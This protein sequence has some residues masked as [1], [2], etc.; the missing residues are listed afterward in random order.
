[1]TDRCSRCKGFGR[2][3][4][5]HGDPGI[6]CRECDD[7]RVPVGHGIVDKPTKTQFEEYLKYTDSMFMFAA[8]HGVGLGD[9]DPDL[10]QVKRWFEQ[11]A[12]SARD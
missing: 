12:A 4:D 9:P 5:D 10:V 2:W 1:M 6:E 11:E 7:G 8:L 3:G